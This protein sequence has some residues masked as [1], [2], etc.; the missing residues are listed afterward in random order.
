MEAAVLQMS[1]T[2]DLRFEQ[3]IQAR[4]ASGGSGPASGAEHQQHQVSDNSRFP[5][6]TDSSQV[7]DNSRQGGF[8]PRSNQSIQ[9]EPVSNTGLHEVGV[10]PPSL[11]PI[12]TNST[13]SQRERSESISSQD[14]NVSFD[15]EVQHI[16]PS[17]ALVD[18]G[19]VSVVVIS[20]ISLPVCSGWHQGGVL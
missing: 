14:R 4:Q 5:G 15:D 3:L 2:I 10:A 16:I 12:L 13:S 6:S 11:R 17:D 18:S 1:K 9:L 20:V 7:A 19:G 8:T